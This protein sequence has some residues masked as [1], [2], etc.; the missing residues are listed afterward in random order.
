MKDMMV[1]NSE[2]QAVSVFFQGKLGNATASA[3]FIDRW[4]VDRVF[5]PENMRGNG[6][7]K[8]LLLE[9]LDLIRE[10]GGGRVEVC[11]GGYNMKYRDQKAFYQSCGFVEVEK[12]RMEI[13]VKSKD[14]R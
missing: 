4:W 3:S 12:G 10:R 9:V 6:L 5:V 2:P 14:P 8:K 7:G 13:T 11:P 1:R